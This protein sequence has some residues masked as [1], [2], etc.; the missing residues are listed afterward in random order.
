MFFCYELSR[1]SFEEEKMNIHQTESRNLLSRAGT[2][3]TFLGP[4]IFSRRARPY[5][6]FCLKTRVLDGE[7]VWTER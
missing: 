7:I 4:V 5:L 2:C 1:V 6:L 3:A